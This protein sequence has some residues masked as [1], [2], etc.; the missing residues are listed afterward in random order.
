MIPKAENVVRDSI[1]RRWWWKPNYDVLSTNVSCSWDGGS[2]YEALNASL[3]A[4]IEAGKIITAYYDT[5][6]FDPKYE[7]TNQYSVSLHP[8]ASWSLFPIQIGT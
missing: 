2:E 7:K 1:Q 5:N 4:P 3:H 6:D 8:F